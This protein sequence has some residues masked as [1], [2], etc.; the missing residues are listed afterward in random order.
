V[1]DVIGEGTLDLQSVSV[2][3]PLAE[4]YRAVK[5]PGKSA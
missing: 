3:I 4:I 2:S 5:L 1:R